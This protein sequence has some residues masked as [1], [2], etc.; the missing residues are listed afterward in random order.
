MASR[1]TVTKPGGW[2]SWGGSL[3]GRSMRF[4]EKYCV[5][6]ETRT[7][8]VL[9]DYQ[10]DLIEQWADPTLKAHA[11]VIGAGN[12]KTTTLAAFV[13]AHLFLTEEGDVPI[14][15][16]TV[17]QAW[18]TTLGTAK[19]FAQLHPDLECRSDVLEGQGS[20]QGVYVPYRNGR[21]YAKAD[22][23]GG[24]QGLKPS[25]TVLEEMSVASMDTFAALMARQG[26]RPGAKL[27]GIS[28]PSFMENNALITVQRS[29]HG[30][31][32]MPNVGLTEYVSSAK[33]HR[34]ES[35]WHEANPALSTEPAVLDIDALRTDLA[36]MAEMQFR[37]YR[38]CQ[39]PVGAESCWLNAV[40]DA[41]DEM[42]DAYDVWKR[43]AS[44]HRFV[45]GAPTW[46]GVDVAKTGDHA[47]VVLGQFREDGRLHAKAKI[48]T[49]PVEGAIDLED[50]ADHL[51]WAQH[52]Y[53]LQ[54]V[55]FDPSYFYN[56]PAL[57]RE[58]LPMVEVPP[59][60]AQMAPL[61]LHAY[62]AV[63]RTRI[64]H[65]DDENFTQHVLNAKRKY[66]PRGFTLE[67]RHFQ[68]K[69]DAA[70]ALV[71]MHGAATG[72]EEPEHDPDTFRI[73]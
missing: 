11:T 68:Q 50:I 14:I 66:G 35:L 70:I 46:A 60:E 34:D 54:H 2:E 43:G 30:G 28:T 29:F 63:R 32:E 56:A 51:R 67:K 13:T 16:D 25:L 33:D 53:D 9:H 7:P 19:R 40:D 21:A 49:P 1:K 22:L 8:M 15:A 39:N 72:M 61:A 23:V 52:E 26:K 20:R 38:L 73:Y 24:L 31:Q 48:W 18:S 57:H 5:L 58:G 62:Q 3:A 64:T 36:L 37:C 44:A 6:P 27:V 41:G 69:C 65:D 71:L 10:R 47:A 55:W 59:T 17:S 12:A 42:G 4:I 45:A